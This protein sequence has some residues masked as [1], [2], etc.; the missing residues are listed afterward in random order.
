MTIQIPISADTEA[1]LRKQAEA[2]GKDITSFVL[3]VLEDK[4]DLEMH[5]INKDGH[6]DL[7]ANQWIARLRRWTSSHRPLPYEADDSRESIYE[8]RGE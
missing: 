6:E 7:P 4:L 8:G 3:E 5:T 2:A 1:K